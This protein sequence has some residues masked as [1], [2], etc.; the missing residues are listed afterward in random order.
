MGSGGFVEALLGFDAREELRTGF[1]ALESDDENKTQ[2]LL[3][4]DLSDVL[5]ADTMIW[6][7]LYDLRQP[8]VSQ[9]ASTVKSAPG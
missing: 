6:P 5:S 2:F 4:T 3:R 9:T 1:R 8:E 7:S